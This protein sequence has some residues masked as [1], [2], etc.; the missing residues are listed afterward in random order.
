M[1]AAGRMHMT[2]CRGLW[3]AKSTQH[4]KGGIVC[5]PSGPQGRASLAS[6][7]QRRGG[8][9]RPSPTASLTAQ[10]ASLA[11]SPSHPPEQRR[12]RAAVGDDWHVVDLVT[13]HHQG[14]VVV[15]AWTVQVQQHITQSTQ[16]RSAFTIGCGSR[17]LRLGRHTAAGCSRRTV[18]PLAPRTMKCEPSELA[19]SVLLW[20]GV[21]GRVACGMQGKEREGGDHAHRRSRAG[22]RWVESSWARCRA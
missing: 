6:L 9:G 16:R 1:T 12:G 7:A 3:R 21:V 22:S 4:A 2:P 17:C 19:T 8:R 10:R 15:H 18:P 14:G 20:V 5:L 11:L 13:Q